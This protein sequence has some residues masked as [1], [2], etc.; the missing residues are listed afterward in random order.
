MLTRILLILLNI[1]CTIHPIKAWDTDDLEI[2][3]L[4]EEINKN[5]YEVFGIGQVNSL[6]IMSDNK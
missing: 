5:F 6:P 3:D 4:V 2:F 1:S